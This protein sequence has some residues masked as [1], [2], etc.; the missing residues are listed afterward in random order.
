MEKPPPKV[1]VGL[2]I[3]NGE[4]YMREAIDSVLAQTFEDFELVICDNASQD[5]TEAICRDYAQRDC[6]V[7]YLRHA[8][9]LGAAINHN[10]CFEMSRSPYFLWLMHDDALGPQA[11]E[12]CVAA[13][14]ADPG[15]VLAYP[16]TTEIDADS[17]RIGDY[18][19]DLDLADASPHRRLGKCL[20]NSIQCCA[21]LGLIRSDALQKTHLIGKYRGSDHI[22]LAEL[23]MLGRFREVPER[24]FLHRMH[25]GSSLV[26]NKDN[27]QI[28]QWYDTSYRGKGRYFKW[29]MFWGF[30]AGV[31][32]SPVG[33]IE[34]VRCFW[35]LRR[36][37]I[38]LLRNVGGR[39]KARLLHRLHPSTP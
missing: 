29:R 3:Y 33:V 23:A 11:L 37:A 26:A 32:G 1:T 4:K 30:L 28:M 15:L 7:R 35:E 6:R 34:K 14:D 20:V 24:L 27:G 17:Q 8:K 18:D 16:R 22:L 21:A 12:L 10:V 31:A 13:L 25:E 36:W 19:E 39:Y 2:P 5:A 9:N 38:P